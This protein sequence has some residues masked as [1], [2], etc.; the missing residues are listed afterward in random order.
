[1]IEV[2]NLSKYD[3]IGRRFNN[4]DASK[5]LAD[6]GISSKNICWESE[7]EN[8]EIVQRAHDGIGRKIAPFLTKM[9]RKTGYINGYYRNSKLITNLEFYKKADLLHFHIVHDQYLS[10]RDWVKIAKNKALVWTWHDPFML[11]GHCIYSMGC[12]GYQ[13]GCQSCDH[14]DYHYQVE[15]DRGAKNLTEKLRVVQELDPLVIVA[16]DH[17][18]EMVKQSV[19][20]GK[21]RIKKLPFGIEFA[22]GISQLEAKKLLNIPKENVVIG[23]RASISVYKNLNLIIDALKRIAFDHPSLTLTIITFE[24]EGK[25]SSFSDNFQVIDLGWVDGAEIANYYSAMDY[26]LMPSRAEA[27]GMMGIESMASG[28]V[29]LVTYGTALSSLVAAPDLGMAAQHTPEDFF[30][31]LEQVIMTKRA[32]VDLRAR[33]IEFAKQHNSL[34]HFCKN[35]AAAYQDEMAYFSHQN[36]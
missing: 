15:R 20:W 17:M 18:Y 11:N 26:F 9:S 4:L 3:T 33:C 24:T 14:L 28:A 12:I 8:S 6:Y 21:V 10:P 5:R 27:F 30:N 7:A 25:C 36:R 31:L 35:M 29:P 34:E 16:S 22:D 32:N 19:Y 13:T 1:M 2:V 23:F